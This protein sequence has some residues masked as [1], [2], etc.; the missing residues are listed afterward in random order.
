MICH[1]LL[2]VSL[3]SPRFPSF[4]SCLFD[5]SLPL[6]CKCQPFYGYPYTELNIPTREFP[7]RLDN[8]R[9]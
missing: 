8:V 3:Y 2:C 5:Q 6:Y 4:D 7:H 1:D 9:V